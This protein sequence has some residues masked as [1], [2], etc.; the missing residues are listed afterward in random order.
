LRLLAD[1][2]IV[3]SYRLHATL[4]AV[5]LGTKVFSFAYDERALSLFSDVGLEE[6][7]DYINLVEDHEEV[8]ARL[9]SLLTKTSNKSDVADFHRWEHIYTDQMEMISAFKTLI[10]DFRAG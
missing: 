2:E 3:V 6:G 5:S 9:E 1:A 8:P 10:D 4:P 7:S